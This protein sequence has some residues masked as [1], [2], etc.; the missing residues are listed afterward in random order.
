M[1]KLV[2]SEPLC[3]V[4]FVTA[5]WR[6]LYA[7]RRWSALALPR[8][9]ANARCASWRSKP[10]LARKPLFDREHRAAA[11]RAAGRRRA[12][13]LRERHTS[14][15]RSRPSRRRPASSRATIDA[16]IRDLLSRSCAGSEQCVSRSGRW[17][18]SWICPPAGRSSRA[19]S[20]CGPA[21]RPGWSWQV[22]CRPMLFAKSRAPSPV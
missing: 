22:S 1:G 8:A 6:A 13:V 12:A 18:R 14:R 15:K 4:S 11:H 10:T 9:C 3:T 21:R 19:I 20:H 5:N 17:S 2:R 7:G 16:C